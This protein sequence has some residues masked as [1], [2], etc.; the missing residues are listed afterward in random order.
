[1]PALIR[2][3]YQLFIFQLILRRFAKKYKDGDGKQ[4]T[5]EL[6]AKDGLVSAKI[7]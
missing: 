4:A 5:E 7:R 2:T 3:A 1:M 6:S